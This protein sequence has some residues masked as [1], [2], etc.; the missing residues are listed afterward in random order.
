MGRPKKNISETKINLQDIEPEDVLVDA[1]FYKGNENLLKNNPQIKW[2]PEMEEEMKTCVKSVF[3]FAENYFYITTE[4]GKERIK[5]YKYQKNL[6]K[7]FKSKRYTTVLSSRQS[8]K[9]LADNTL[10][11]IRN[12]Q[13]GEIEEI[14][15]EEFYNR[16]DKKVV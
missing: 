8:G 9:C 3:H 14:T 16:F 12:K 6:L 5:L 1:S 2:S 10:L 11:Q 13:T 4:D 7:A 15:I